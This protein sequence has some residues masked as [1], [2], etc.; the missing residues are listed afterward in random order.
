LS[1]LRRPVGRFNT[2]LLAELRVQALPAEVHRLAADDGSSAQK[3]IRNIERNVSPG[4][5]H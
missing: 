1:R 2:E 4:S 3:P 5:T